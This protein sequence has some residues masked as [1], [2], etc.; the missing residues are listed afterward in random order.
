[1]PFK[2]KRQKLSAAHRRYTIAENILVNYKSDQGESS[3]KKSDVLDGQPQKGVK[4]IEENYS[5]V[6]LDLLKTTTIA[7]AIIAT[8][9]LLLIKI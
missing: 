8:Q 5:Y 3:T 9:L 1:M 2:T 6:K 4:L 7:G